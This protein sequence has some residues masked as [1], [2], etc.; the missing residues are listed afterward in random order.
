MELCVSNL[1]NDDW[2]EIHL[3][4]IGRDFLYNRSVEKVR[5][6]RR[7]YNSNKRPQKSSLQM[8]L[9]MKFILHCLF[10]SGCV[11]LLF[12][13]EAP[14][15]PI[16]AT[17]TGE[18][19]GSSQTGAM[20]RAQA[21][22]CDDLNLDESVLSRK[23]TFEDV[24]TSSDSKPMDGEKVDEWLR[25]LEAEPFEYLKAPQYIREYP[26]AAELVVSKDSS[27]FQ[28]LPTRLRDDSRLLELALRQMDDGWWAL[29]F[30]SDALKANPQIIALAVEIN[31]LSIMHADDIIK[32]D[33]TIMRPLCA[34]KGELL[35]YCG[36]SLKK[37]QDI[38]EV[39]VEQDIYSIKHADKEI[40]ANA[41]FMLAL[42]NK[43]FTVIIFAH[44]SLLESEDFIRK[45]IAVNPIAFNHAKGSLREDVEKMKS[46]KEFRDARLQERTESD[47]VGRASG[48]MEV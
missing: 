48:A 21:L 40:R 41:E 34:L 14:G 44:Q 6:C 30:A 38:V 24:S 42:M 5:A 20:G 11:S 3:N 15:Q 8:N 2:W 28:F 13:S 18:C 16:V 25:R 43:D 33:E 29:K 1:D 4:L 12:A 23:R 7:S 31:P 46:L 35:K 19:Q 17:T 36:D 39:A 26:P 10:A 32:N 9:S 37:R 47:T 27:I 45:A 22:E